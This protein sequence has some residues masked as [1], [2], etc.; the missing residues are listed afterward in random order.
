[1]TSSD[2]RARTTIRVAAIDC[3]T[4]SIRLLVADGDPQTGRLT[5]LTRQLQVVRLG[6]GVDRT[7]RIDPEAMTRTLTA[8]QQYAR[9]CTELGVERVRF[10]ATSASRD[11]QNAAEFVAGVRRVFAAHE[12]TPQV[13][14]G[15]VEAALSFAGATAELRGSGRPGP[16]LV[17]DLG[18]GSTEFVLGTT[19]PDRAVS[20]DMGSV[21]ITERHFRADPPTPAEVAA[22]TSDIDAALDTALAA[23]DPSRAGQLVGLAGTVTTVTAHALGLPEYQRDRIHLSAVSVPDMIAAC[24]DL[25]TMPR[26]QRVR[27]PVLHPGRVDVIAAGALLWRRIVQRVAGLSGLAEVLTSEHDILD[28]I[29]RSL[30]LAPQ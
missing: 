26:P 30:L 8:A 15:E 12:V 20:V 21:R 22:A 2:G 28:G 7:G 23:C 19:R 18:G 14:S 24:T 5:E 9:V 4:N 3:G 16:Y 6:H 17:V 13:V 1:M 11:A 27:L 25:I 10:V 29:A